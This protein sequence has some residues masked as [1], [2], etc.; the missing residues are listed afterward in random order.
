MSLTFNVPINPVSFGQTSTCLLRAA[1]EKG[2]EINTFPIANVDLSAQKIVGDFSTWLQDSINNSILNHNKNIPVFR[3]WHIISS[4]ESVISKF[5]SLFTFHECSNITKYERS[6][7]NSQDQVFVSS[8]Y[9]KSVFESGGV[10]SKVTVCPL[11]F[12]KWNFSKLNKKFYNDDRIVFGIMGKAEI[13]KSTWKLIQ[14]W[15]KKYGNNKN[16]TLHLLIDNHFTNNHY[17]DP[18]ATRKMLLQA[19]E[20]KNY[21]NIVWYD[22]LKT[23]AEVNDWQNC[24]DIDLSGLSLCEGWGIPFFTS[25]C[26]GKHGIALNAHA[27]KMFC[28]DKNSILIEPN[29]MIDAADGLFFGRG[30]IQN[31]GQWFTFND[32]DVISAMSRAE[33]LAKKPN[34]EGEKLKD[35]F[36]YEKSLDII[37][38]NLK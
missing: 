28:S 10:T 26:L 9:T 3:L 12:D 16:Y 36:N 8:S 22:S 33:S 27:N 19:L 30:G 1:H 13:R 20:G 23:N 37:T 24:L 7:L 4:M 21:W 15:A 32:D 17:K 11:G 2:L 6:V 29:G 35:F 25:L 14:L 38:E 34:T 18:A 5:N 31:D